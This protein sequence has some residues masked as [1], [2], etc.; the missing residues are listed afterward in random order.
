MKRVEARLTDEQY[1]KFKSLNI[2]FTKFVCNA[3]DGSNLTSRLDSLFGVVNG[4]RVLIE[5][6]KTQPT[7]TYNKFNNIKPSTSQGKMNDNMSAFLAREKGD[8]PSPFAGKVRSCFNCGKSPAPNR[9]NDYKKY[10]CD[11]CMEELSEQNW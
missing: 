11:E 4:I 10:A 3:L 6:Q 1:K 5:E 8:T 2:G 9:T 7:H